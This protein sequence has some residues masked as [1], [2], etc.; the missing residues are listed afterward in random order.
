VRGERGSRELGS[1]PTSA[2]C[3]GR[4][5]V[6]F[7]GRQ[8]YG[9]RFIMVSL[10]GRTNCRLPLSYL[11]VLSCVYVI[12]VCLI[13]RLLPE[14]W[15]HSR[16]RITSHLSGGPLPR[17]RETCISP[18]AVNAR[19]ARSRHPP[20]SR[21]PKLSPTH[22]PPSH[23]PRRYGYEQSSSN[24]AGAAQRSC[25]FWQPQH[26]HAPEHAQPHRKSRSGVE[27][28]NC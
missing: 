14:W 16:K 7:H 11:R 25:R 3:N 27:D 13:E 21:L 12:S 23:L 8:S 2:E 6:A 18:A 15:S 22:R 19:P 10:H 5:T 9:A 20:L 1:Q 24:R 26:R 4:A 28:D 17:L